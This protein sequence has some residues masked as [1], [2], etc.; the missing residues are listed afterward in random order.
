MANM[1]HECLKRL[2][3]SLLFHDI[4]I[5]EIGEILDYLK[6]MVKNTENEV[7]TFADNHVT[8]LE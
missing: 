8:V 1:S 6:P 5:E 4:K 7:I 2:S 3:G